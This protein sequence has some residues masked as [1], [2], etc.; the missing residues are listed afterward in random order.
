VGST[1]AFEWTPGILNSASALNLGG[2]LGISPSVGWMEETRLSNSVRYS[3]ATYT[4]PTQS[5]AADVNTR[6]LWH[7][8]EPT[9]STT[10]VDSSGNSNTL[11]GLNGAQTGNP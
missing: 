7:Y 11:T 8:E 6:A 1:T 10:M 2:Y 4:V 5:F 9:G 3:G